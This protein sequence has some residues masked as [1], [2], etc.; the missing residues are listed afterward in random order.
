MLDFPHLWS[1]RRHQLDSKVVV[2]R[3]RGFPKCSWLHP[4]FY[5]MRIRSSAN[6]GKGSCIG[7]AD[8]R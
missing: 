2:G 3:M 6:A 7:S 5:E 4:I 8:A 1:R